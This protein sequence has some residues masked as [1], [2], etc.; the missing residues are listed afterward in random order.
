MDA[1]SELFYRLREAVKS[2]SHSIIEQIL[3]EEIFRST[4]KSKDSH[5]GENR[6]TLVNIAVSRNDE[7]TVNRLLDYG[8]TINIDENRCQVIPPL[9]YAVVLGH[10]RIAEILATRVKEHVDQRTSGEGYYKLENGDTALHAASRCG[11]DRLAAILLKNGATIDAPNSKSETALHLAIGAMIK[12]EARLAM[13]R[14]LLD[15]AAR[16]DIG[17]KPALLLAIAQ[18]Q[19]DVAHLIIDQREDALEKKDSLGSGAMHYALKGCPANIE[20]MT[21]LVNKGIQVD[22]PNLAGKRPL[23]VAV[24]YRNAVMTKFLLDHG[25][26]IDATT[27]SKETPLYF[28]ALNGDM[29]M[30][31]QL[32]DAGANIHVTTNR[33]QTAFHAACQFGSVEMVCEMLKFGAKINGV[34]TY[35]QTPLYFACSKQSNDIVKTL[36][37]S[38]ANPNAM[39]DIPYDSPLDFACRRGFED[40]VWLLLKFGVQMKRPVYAYGIGIPFDKNIT[41]MLIKHALLAKHQVMCE[42]FFTVYRNDPHFA[43]CQKELEMMKAT[44]FYPNLTFFKMLVM[45]QE[46][47]MWMMRNVKVRE[48]FEANFKEEQFPMYALYFTDR[49]ADVKQML[50]ERDLAEEILSSVFSTILPVETINKVLDYV[51]YKDIRFLAKFA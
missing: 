19:L 35:T 11:L 48:A 38:G 45:Q 43:K 32:L 40:T 31:K 33:E 39:T 21:M 46:E 8:V 30:V 1:Y 3:G 41:I 49:F 23:H 51:S 10:E 20:F 26:D 2:S 5:S 6:A 15:H 28:A 34:S 13:V 36:L 16:I 29:S 12:A 37:E 17:H 24:R 42:Q 25:A 7:E 47:L 50:K 27:E 22:E 18:N 4:L 14:C 9:V 44:E